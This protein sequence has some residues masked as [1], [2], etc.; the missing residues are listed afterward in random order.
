MTTRTRMM[1]SITLALIGLISVPAIAQ[2]DLCDYEQRNNV[3]S[4]GY[5]EVRYDLGLVTVNTNA[6]L[7]VC[8]FMS[9]ARTGIS[10]MTIVL[11]GMT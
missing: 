6:T 7:A 3:R 10:D 1:S 8:R 9:N 11:A 5:E 2:R 4:S